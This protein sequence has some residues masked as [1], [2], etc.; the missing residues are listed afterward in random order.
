MKILHLGDL[1]IGKTFESKSLLAEQEDALRQVLEVIQNKDIDVMI[2]AGDIYDRSV[3]SEESIRLYNAFIGLAL[4][5]E[6][7]NIL[8]I[9]GNHDSSVRLGQMSSLL[10]Q[11]RYHVVTEFT[12]PLKKITL[13]DEYGE[14]D[15]YFMPYL[16]SYNIRKI[17]NIEEKDDNTI[18]SKVLDMEYS[19]HRKVLM[20]HNY[21]SSSKIE[22]QSETCESERRLNI[23]GMDFINSDILEKFNYVALGHLHGNQKVGKEY[24]RYSGTL[25]KYSLSEMN[26]KKLINIVELKEDGNIEIETIP[27]KFLRDIREIRGK[28]QDIIRTNFDDRK[29]DYLSVVLEDSERIEDGYTRLS[30]VY[31]NIIKLSYPNIAE[32]KGNLRATTENMTENIFDIFTEFFKSKEGREMSPKEHEIMMEIIGGLEIE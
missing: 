1:H 18:Y 27:V 28:F 3:P 16:D 30:K 23:G 13:N 11:M 10:S 25:L 6:K 8:V 2:I 22:E 29:D 15:F 17:Y 20:A 14:V 32:Q 24:I 5:N 7:L 9:S 4:K 31:P 21:F 19:K 26:H 12:N